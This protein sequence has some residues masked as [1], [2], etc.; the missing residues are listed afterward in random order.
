MSNK[1]ASKIIYGGK[2]LIDLTSDTVAPQFLAEG[3][4]AHDASGE[5]IVG[6]MA[7]E[8]IPDYVKA[9]AAETA[10]KVLSHQSEDSFTLAWFSDLHVGT[11]LKINGV[12]TVDETSII[13]AG[14]GLHEMSKSAPC[15]MIALGGDLSSGNSST[16]PEEGLEQLDKCTEYLRPATFYSPT[17]YLKGNHDDAPYRATT[18][19]LT[20]ADLFSRFGKKNLLAGAVSNDADKGCNYGYLD[21]VNRKMRVIYL[22]THDKDG[23]ES[24]NEST[25]GSDYMDACNVSAKQLDWL[26]NVALD[27]SDK[28]NPSK[29]GV[30]V[31]SHTQLDIHAGDHTYTDETSGKSYTANTINVIDILTAYL[32]RGSGSITLNGETANYDFSALD[33]TA[34]LYCC[35]N[36]H[37]HAYKFRQHGI[38][39][40][41][42]I[43]CPNTR[44]G[45]ERESDDGNTYTKTP[46]TGNGTTFNVITI[47]RKNGKI[48]A[49]NYGAGID[50]VFDVVVYAT[51]TNL[52]PQATTPVAN[53]EEPVEEIYNGGLGYKN[54]TRISGFED[55]SL[56]GYVATGYVPY[57]RKADKTY[58]DIY[59]KGATL[60]TSLSYVRGVMVQYVAG[61]G[62][63]AVRYSSGGSTDAN[64]MWS[65]HF[66]IE[67]LGE[68]YYKLTP[69]ELITSNHNII[70]FRMSLL[71]SGE[72]LIITVDEPIIGEPIIDPPDNET[73]SYTNQ[74]PISTDGSGN[75][76][77]GKGYKE[78]S[79]ISSGAEGT[80]D[81][82][83]LSGF[84]P[85]K[86]YDTLYF[87]NV[88]MSTNNGNYRVAFYNADKSFTGTQLTTAITNYTGWTYGDD[89]NLSSFQVKVSGDNQDTAY[90]R[91][92]CGY[93]G[94]DSIVTVNEPIE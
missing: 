34:Y 23:W 58:G 64:T 13:E 48:Y 1:N 92:C 61:E 12:W 79:Y 84:I 73:V 3:V 89:G 26:A 59:I 70:A 41:P 87:K 93:L 2:T 37:N 7:A 6:T 69:S 56:A 11:A 47:D 76:F 65:T 51:Y 24:T 71:G 29:W 14:Q 57:R 4:T 77:N 17:L 5:R 10:K 42:A 21:F 85:C 46:G 49:D 62:V 45:L 19:R 53:D 50:R 63:K 32:S 60:D 94:E 52:V 66:T 55:V 72:K 27:F 44:A 38:K 82:V 91:F 22:D 68:Q 67:E 28:D 88:V 18:D 31:L 35:I 54:N 78:N 74:L 20:R 25:S 75:V 90:I 15:D 39:K 30:I 86:L 40:I 16:Y 9:E 8:T 80:R 81:G 83:Y 33:D 36:G 43:T